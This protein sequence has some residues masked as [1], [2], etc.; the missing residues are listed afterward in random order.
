MLEVEASPNDT[1]TAQP[2]DGVEEERRSSEHLSPRGKKDCPPSAGDQR[3]AAQCNVVGP[4][5]LLRLLSLLS[6]RA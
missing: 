4:V 1:N 3:D 6:W 2:F 5:L